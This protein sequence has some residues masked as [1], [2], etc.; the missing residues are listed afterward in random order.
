MGK[1]FVRLCTVLFFL[2][3]AFLK[4]MVNDIHTMEI[5]YI[6]FILEMETA[7]VS[8]STFY[9]QGRFVRY[10]VGPRIH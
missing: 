4:E 2:R 7:V 9:N 1:R 6:S 10:P 3:S 8:I 5:L